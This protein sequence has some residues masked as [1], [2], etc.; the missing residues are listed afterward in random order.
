MSREAEIRATYK[1]AK[2]SQIA[3]SPQ[4][5]AEQREHASLR[6]LHRMQSC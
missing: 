1:Q 3:S 5:L 4:K 6:P 2:G